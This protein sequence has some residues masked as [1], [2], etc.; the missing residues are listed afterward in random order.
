MRLNLSRG[1]FILIPI[2]LLTLLGGG[3]WSRRELDKLGFIG[4]VAI[5]QAD[6]PELLEVTAQFIIPKASAQGGQSDMGGGKG[7]GNKVWVI[8]AQGPTV[9]EALFKINA[10]SANYLF[11]GHQSSIIIGEKAARKGVKEIIDS[12]DR[13]P[14][15]RRNTWLIIT[16][17]K[18]KSILQANP[19]MQDIPS[20]TI[21]N[22]FSHQGITS[23]SYP[24]TLN[25]FL[26]TV[27]SRSTSP[28]VARLTT[29]I[30]K[31]GP[32]TK[33]SPNL[34]EDSRTEIKL[35][36]A[37]LLKHD[38]LAGWLDGRETRGVLWVQNKI[39]RGTI[40][41]P[42]PRGNHKFIT[43][44]ILSGKRKIQTRIKD[45]RLFV[46]LK[47]T[48]DSNVVDQTSNADILSRKL[49]NEE[50]N[51]KALNAAMSSHVK[52]EIFAAIKKAQQFQA[53]LF[54]IGERFYIEHPQEFKKLQKDWPKLIAQAK[55]N[56]DID[57]KIRRVG[58]INRSVNTQFPE[59]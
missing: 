42:N 37:A 9:F 54:G 30:N 49:Y 12:F 47:I 41:F 22:L 40:T 57:V 48:F 26:M 6:N 46:D 3:C 18:A 38:K 15:L 28:V 51:V 4:S 43:F 1:A 35:E 19:K 34:G 36:G 52:M 20:L 55:F 7:G 59:P 45:G 50:E 29:V 2:L 56:I 27:V 39:K 23:V 16:P 58:L 10:I 17:G 24:S 44:E 53:D 21:E 32:Q 13:M 31:E 25:N 14:Q 5:D 11:F 33:Q 8:S